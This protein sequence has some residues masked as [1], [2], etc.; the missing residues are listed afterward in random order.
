MLAFFDERGS[1]DSDKV[2]ELELF[3]TTLR[4]RYVFYETAMIGSFVAVSGC[5]Y[6]G[7]FAA[8]ERF[9]VSAIS[10]A[11]VKKL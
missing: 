9:L 4:V 8:R 2:P 3:S 11:S 5:L 6:L 7:L 1:L 10:S